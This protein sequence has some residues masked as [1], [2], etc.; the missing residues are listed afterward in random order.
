MAQILFNKGEQAALDAFLGGQGTGGYQGSAPSGQVIVPSAGSNWGLGM[1]TATV[2]ALLAGA[3]KAS[4]I[5]AIGEIGG[6]TQ[7]GYGRATISRDQAP[8][9]GWPAATNVAG[10]YQTTGPQKTFT[11]T[12]AP[13]PN[14]ANCWFVAGSATI[15][16]DNALFGADTAAPRTFANGDTERITPTFRAS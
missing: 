1:G 12:G 5:A 13:S 15:G 16:H 6:V 2:T 10:S 9:T 7:A 11:F 8:G 4:G 3:G 14:T